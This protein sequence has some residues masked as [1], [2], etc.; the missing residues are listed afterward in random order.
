MKNKK[1]KDK[2]KESVI[3]ILNYCEKHGVFAYND[4]MKRSFYHSLIQ[5]KEFHE[6]QHDFKK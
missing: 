3:Y 4:Y 6:K 2:L 1:T 5:V